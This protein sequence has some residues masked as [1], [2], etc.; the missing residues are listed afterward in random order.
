MPYPELFTDASTSEQIKSILT[1]PAPGE[2]TLPIFYKKLKDIKAQLQKRGGSYTGPFY[3]NSIRLI[4]CA[5]TLT[6]DR[7][8]E[9]THA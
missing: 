2:M 1:E 3:K 4:K 9:I 6:L 8:I 5:N 7:F